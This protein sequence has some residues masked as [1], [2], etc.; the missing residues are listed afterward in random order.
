MIQE[1][2]LSRT[3]HLPVALTPIAGREGETAQ[4]IAQ[5]GDPASRLV[6]IMGPGGTGKTL[7]CT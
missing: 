6:T 7:N 4:L 3:H 5:L 1:P 2:V